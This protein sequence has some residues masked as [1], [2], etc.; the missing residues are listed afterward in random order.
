MSFMNAKDEEIIRDHLLDARER[1]DQALGILNR[2]R[3]SSPEAS[4]P[5]S[6]SEP[7]PDGAWKTHPA[8]EKQNATLE[9]FKIQYNP[10]ITKG[11]AAV[12][13]QGLFSRRDK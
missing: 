7:I 13:I 5:P 6:R 10:N 2:G 11:E 3:P 8:S 4:A 9:K 1:I 12:I